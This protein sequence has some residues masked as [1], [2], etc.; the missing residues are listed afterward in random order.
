MIA[1]V[2]EGLAANGEAGNGAV[3]EKVKAQAIDLCN[4]FPIYS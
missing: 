1:E 2:L 3:E 4:R